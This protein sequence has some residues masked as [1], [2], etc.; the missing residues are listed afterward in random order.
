MS[1]LLINRKW[2]WKSNYDPS[3]SINASRSRRFFT[4]PYSRETCVVFIH[5]SGTNSAIWHKHSKYVRV[6]TMPCAR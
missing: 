4:S 3:S 1:A 6:C 2:L 5:P